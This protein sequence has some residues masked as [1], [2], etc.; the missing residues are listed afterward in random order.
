MM[1]YLWRLY[2]MLWCKRSHCSGWWES[3]LFLALHKHGNGST[4]FPLLVL[5]LVSE[6]FSHASAAQY[7]AR[8]LGDLASLPF[9]IFCLHNSR[10]LWP[11]WTSDSISSTWQDH[12]ALCSGLETSGNEVGHFPV[13]PGLFLFPQESLSCTLLSSVFYL[14]SNSL[15]EVKEYIWSLL[16]HYGQSRSS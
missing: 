4:Y 6:I 9:P 8:D 2:S 5:F 16:F 11:P 15:F 10:C 3:R 1:R 7:S 13:I 14:L 12:C